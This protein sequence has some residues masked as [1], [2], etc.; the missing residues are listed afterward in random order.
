MF[1]SVCTL[2]HALHHCHVSWYM[3][4]QR[5]ALFYVILPLSLYFLLSYRMARLADCC[6][7]VSVFGSISSV[8]LDGWIRCVW[9]TSHRMLSCIS[10]LLQVHS[11]TL[12]VTLTLT[13]H[14]LVLSCLE[15][16]P[17][18]SLLLFLHL[19]NRQ[20]FPYR[21]RHH[22]RLSNIRFL[23]LFNYCFRSDSLNFIF[24]FIFI[25]LTI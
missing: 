5:T 24:V 19:S 25:S 16:L 11:P 8:L 18:S 22:F 6:F 15:S 17:S 3:T 23:N 21:M 9:H 14:V 10:P 7:L 2:I 12:T 4:P 20:T 13:L 1:H